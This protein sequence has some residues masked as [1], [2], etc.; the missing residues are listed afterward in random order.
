MPT[1]VYPSLDSVQHT[2]VLAPCVVGTGITCAGP[3]LFEFKPSYHDLV[4]QENDVLTLDLGTMIACV[5]SHAT[6]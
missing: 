1:G 2:Q 5:V 4:T 6:D 3:R